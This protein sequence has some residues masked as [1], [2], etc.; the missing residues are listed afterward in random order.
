MQKRRR[1][2]FYIVSQE[3]TGI[4]VTGGTL[5]LYCNIPVVHQEGM[6]TEVNCNRRHKFI[7][8]LIHRAHVF[9]TKEWVVTRELRRRDMC[10]INY[11]LLQEQEY[12]VPG[13]AISIL[14]TK[15]I[16]S[17]HAFDDD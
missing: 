8:T 2:S 15:S 10:Y 4:L 9:W 3:D 14:M 12:R 11:Y 1:N 17:Q 5:L 7:L 13:G 16:K 6:K